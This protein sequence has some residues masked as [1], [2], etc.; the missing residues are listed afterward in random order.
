M[1]SSCHKYLVIV[2]RLSGTLDSG[3]MIDASSIA[4][5]MLCAVAL[6]R[7]VGVGVRLGLVIGIGFNMFAGRLSAST[8]LEV[9]VDVKI[10]DQRNRCTDRPFAPVMSDTQVAPAYKRNVIAL[11]KQTKS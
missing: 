5:N 10:V 6:T 4:A 9:R 1:V 2:T 7:L 3:T 11:L 8:F